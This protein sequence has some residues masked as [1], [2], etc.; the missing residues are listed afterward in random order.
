MVDNVFNFY[1]Y[2]IN[3][4][5][6]SQMNIAHCTASATV[7]SV[8]F[9]YCI[10]FRNSND[11]CKALSNKLLIPRGKSVRKLTNLDQNDYR[12]PYDSN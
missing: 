11:I 8:K 5:I 7:Q 2:L 3:L 6:H 4:Y 10:F 12:S 9:H 1:V